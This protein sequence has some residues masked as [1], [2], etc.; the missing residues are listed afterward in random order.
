MFT[1]NQSA[2]PFV[3]TRQALLVLD[4]QNDLV[5]PGGLLHVESPSSFVERTVNLAN[6][7][8][9]SGK[10]IWIRSRFEASRPV[11]DVAFDCENVI[12][13]HEVIQG[14]QKRLRS[15]WRRR[16]SS[17]LEQHEKELEADG[18]STTELT[19]ENI[20]E[21]SRKEAFLT[22]HSCEQHTQAVEPDSP[23]A[24]FCDSVKASMA[25]NDD[26]VFQKSYY[27]AFKDGSLVQTLRGQ[28]VTEIYICGAL[29]NISV[30]ATAMD[31]A[32]HG[33]AITLVEDCLGYGSKARH[34]EAVLRLTD[35]TGCAVI[36]SNEL[37]ESFQPRSKGKT[38][39]PC[40][41][42]P[43]SSRQDY[44]ELESS[45]AGLKIDGESLPNE[46]QAEM[47]EALEQS[48][49]PDGVMQ[50]ERVKSKIRTRRRP[51]MD[52][53]K[54]EKSRVAEKSGNSPSACKKSHLLPAAASPELQPESEIP[55]SL[56]VDEQ[57]EYEDLLL[58]Y[59]NQLR[60]N[61]V[62]AGNKTKEMSSADTD[63]VKKESKE[64]SKAEN[65]AAPHEKKPELAGSTVTAEPLELPLSKAPVS[66]CEGDT[67]VIEN[68]LPVDVEIGIFEKL[69]DEI[70]WQ[71]MSHQGGEVP[72][73]VAVQG[74][75]AEDGSIPI[76]R[77][78]ADESPPLHAFSPT[79]RLIKQHVEE[80]LGH[81]VNHV[82]IQFYRGGTDYISEHSDKTLDI[83]PNTFIANVS[84]GAQR[85]MT[86]RTKKPLKDG[87]ASEGSEPVPRQSYRAPLPHNS[88]CKMGL[89]TNMRWLHSIRQD[90]RMVSEKSE[91]ELA[92]DC[93]RI[94]LTF[95]LIGTFL[96]R[97]QS[98]IWGQGATCKIKE[99][100][101]AVINGDTK[102]SKEMLFA[103]G[104]ENHSTEFNWQE[105]Y[106][107]GFDV[108]HISNTRKLFLSGDTISDLRVKMILA[109][110]GL[111]WA[112][113][114]LS[115]PFKWKNGSPCDDT[116]AV[117]E[118][119]PIKL[120]DNDPSHSIVEG[121]LAILLYLDANYRLKENAPPKSQATIARQFSRL[122]ATENLIKSW[123]ASRSCA[124][125]FRHELDL[126]ETLAA[127][128]EF[129]AG[130]EMTV[131]DL[132]LWP[133]VSEIVKDVSWSL[134]G[135]KS[136][137]SYYERI[138]RRPTIAAIF[139]EPG[140]NDVL[141]KDEDSKH[142]TADG[143]GKGK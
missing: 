98:K 41:R 128:G 24:D 16:R 65:M 70:R 15:S 53:D 13:D 36:T 132:A 87:A 113:A 124:R 114:K 84:L 37:I 27:S 62:D 142:V 7:F 102:E 64:E 118:I 66:I 119:L 51:K 35:F 69:R 23:G 116:P 81:S 139:A 106:G 131:A 105:V 32:R 38:G 80:R 42:K 55:A 96:N 61:V 76:Y 44:S 133:V 91:A 85:T 29:S 92:Y 19:G 20:D 56:V 100:A 117:P 28:F 57:E 22:V 95:R 46:S 11:N 137:K 93:G 82:L 4:L 135:R 94:S 47:P 58:L 111:E 63:V 21:A 8:R 59:G 75:I 90:K 60:N 112:E 88:L 97:D 54:P 127:E 136:L 121:D 109:E 120:V 14:M 40:T 34:D 99:G 73:L 104:K 31:A 122:F 18:D 141:K 6:Q 101:C 45:F 103:F 2:L 83:M 115:P 50:K 43:T 72:R 140:G 78:P 25:G 126:W 129:I 143:D 134:D 110:Y 5:S 33:Y 67:T 30:F 130:P 17:I 108:L 52:G 48:I 79:V 89:V 1:I 9:T 10:V 123:H 74:E 26:M 39:R 107:A 86:F 49:G 77:H 3:Q 12:T 125:A 68:L 138:Q 71:K